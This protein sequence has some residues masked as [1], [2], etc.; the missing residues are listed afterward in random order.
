MSETKSIDSSLFPELGLPVQTNTFSTGVLPS[1]DL[2]QAKL[3]HRITADIEITEEQIQ[4]ASIDLR[5][6]TV[7]YRVQ[8]SFLPSQRSTV[9]DKISRLSMATISLE[10]PTL[11]EKDCVYI[12]PA[13]E[14]FELPSD[15]SGYAN[16]RSTTGRLDIF[17]RLIADY[18]SAFD[19]IPKGYTGN[20]FLEV[21]PR[22]FPIIVSSGMR[23]CQVRLVRGS[24]PAADSIISAL[25]E[26]ESLVFVDSESP[27]K[28]QINKGLWFSVS[29]ETSGESQVVAYKAK[30]NTPAV[31]L[32]KVN[33]YEPDEFWEPIL[34][35]R[36][37]E[38]VL[39]PGGFY[40]LASKERVRVPID[41]AAEMVP[42]DASIGEFR[43]HYAGFFDPGFG[44]GSSDIKGTR[45]VLEVRAHDVPA[46]IEDGQYLGRLRYMRLLCR[47]DKIYSQQIGSSYQCQEL[48]L[49][50]QFK[51][52]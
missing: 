6:G 17:T 21:V 51:R 31:D 12:I 46:L 11:L 32:S 26:E 24:P 30:R 18:S 15:T 42:F 38:L 44:Y 3:D 43:V 49:S 40:I 37:K 34:S 28:A 10:S 36:S 27:G 35:P 52:T 39:D 23:L 16:P 8:A 29:L 41:V 33:Y 50:K 47:P 48:T 22:A 25:D 13:M 45:A 1:Q 14:R 7:A 2:R 5:L 20:V 19:R 9:A 4:P